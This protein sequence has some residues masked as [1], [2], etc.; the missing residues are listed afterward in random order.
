MNRLPSRREQETLA[1]LL[2]VDF[3]GRDELRLPAPTLRVIGKCGCG[4]ATI[5]VD[6]DRTASPPAPVWDTSPVGASANRDQW[7]VHLL[8]SDGYL[9]E[10]EIYAVTGEPPSEFPAPSELDPP[11][12][13]P[14][15]KGHL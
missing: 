12:V 9:S 1:Y 10:I 6:A 2:S 3:P 13:F 4:C 7:Y 15:G 8:V 11:N 5:K 14:H